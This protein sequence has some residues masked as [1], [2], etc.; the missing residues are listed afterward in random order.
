MIRY[1]RQLPRPT[2]KRYTPL[3]KLGPV[4]KRGTRLNPDQVVDLRK[5][6]WALTYRNGWGGRVIRQ[7][8]DIQPTPGQAPRPV[9]RWPFLSLWKRG[10]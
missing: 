4:F 5:K 8:K 3:P 2:N 7:P 6:P 9:R 10:T 1:P